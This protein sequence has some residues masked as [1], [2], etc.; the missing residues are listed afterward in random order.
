M[1]QRSR[2]IPSLVHETSGTGIL[3]RVTVNDAPSGSPGPVLRLSTRPSLSK[4]EV[5][6][7]VEING[8]R[9]LSDDVI[10]N[11]FRKM[12]LDKTLEIVFYDGVVKTEDDLLRLL[13]SPH[14]Y[15]A[16]VLVDGNIRAFAWFN[17]LHDGYATAHFCVFKESWGEEAGE[18]GK[19]VLSYWFSFKK[20]DG[21]PMFNLILGVTPSHY[22]HALRFIATLGFQT[23]G[24]VPRILYNAYL[25]KRVNAIL[26]YCERPT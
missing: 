14:N 17:D 1:G 2:V 22:R 26:S 16:F 5:F 25:N 8:A 15:P 11:V 12:Q 23:I 20:E 6:P 7:Y 9:T 10:R 18:M 3:T 24:K 13:K 19:K 21:S 4:I